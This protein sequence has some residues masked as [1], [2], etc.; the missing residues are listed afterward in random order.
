MDVRL[1]SQCAHLDSVGYVRREVAGDLVI[2]CHIT[3]MTDRATNFTV[4]L[5]APRSSLNPSESTV[6]SFPIMSHGESTI[7]SGRVRN[8]SCPDANSCGSPRT[9][10]QY[11]L[12]TCS[13][14]SVAAGPNLLA[15]VLS[16]E[17]GM[18]RKQLDELS[19]FSGQARDR[20]MR[21]RDS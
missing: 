9:Y 19:F 14:P 13:G 12:M 2:C 16:S 5:G 20:R 15:R 7:L 18:L 11:Q 1:R 4:Q 21:C 3:T 8:T 10:Y 17:H 6:A